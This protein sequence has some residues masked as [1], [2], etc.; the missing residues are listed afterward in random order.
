MGLAICV[1]LTM[2]SATAFLLGSVAVFAP[3]LIYVA[4]ITWRIAEAI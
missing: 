4:W 2:K 3:V 1:G